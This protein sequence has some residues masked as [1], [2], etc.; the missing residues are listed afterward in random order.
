MGKITAVTVLKIKDKG[1][2]PDGDNL[3]LQVGAT[4]TKSWLF[5]YMLNG[6]A[7]NM[8]LGSANAISLA[9][10]RDKAAEARKL[11][12]SGIDPQAD[13]KARIEQAKLE[14]A[15]EMTFEQCATAYIT[16]HKDGWKNAKHIWQ[17]ENTLERFVYPIFGKLPVQDVDVGL[18][19]KVLEPIWKTKTETATRVRGRIERVL[20]WANSREYRSG[21]NPARWRGKLENLL[22]APSKIRKVCHQP[23]LPYHKIADFIEQIKQIDS[24]PSLA[25]QLTILTATRTGE[26]LNAKW[27]EIDLKNC[28]WVIPAER[29]KMGKEHRVPL[30]APALK[31]LKKLHEAQINDFVFPSNKGKPLSNMAMMMMVRRMGRDDFVVHGFRSTFRDWCAEQTNYPREIAE[32]ALAHAV[33]DKVEAAYRRS[34]LFEKRRQLMNEW[35]RYCETPRVAEGDKVVKL[36]KK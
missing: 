4:G 13:K 2:Y 27:Q 34:D 14:A 30:T 1:C 9:E 3:Y 31:I 16:A 20:D 6:K 10:A 24:L 23:A 7:K 25:L 8:G 29:M 35:A 26:T 15:K 21:E 12:A 11:L 22:P 5:R 36:R 17:W 33:G 19:M 32:A 28:V 18:V